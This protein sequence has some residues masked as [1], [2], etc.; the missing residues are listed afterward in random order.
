MFWKGK[1][2]MKRQYLFMVVLALLLSLLVP[3]LAITPLAGA[4]ETPTPPLTEPGPYGV[5]Q[6]RMTFI[7][8]SRGDRELET[9]IWYPVDK[10]RGTPIVP[11]GRVLNAPPDR[12]GAPYPLIVFSHDYRSFGELADTLE[13]L[14]SQGYVVAA[15]W[16]HDTQPFRYELVD[17][18]LDILVVLDGLAAITEGDLAGMI[19]TD[20]VGLMGFS[21]GGDTVLQMLGLLRDPVHFASWCAEH[22]DLTTWDCNPPPDFGPWP[23]DEITAYRAQLGLQNTPDGQWAPFGDERVRAVFAIAPGE[24]PLTTED[25]LASVTTPTM[26]LHGTNDTVCDYEGN[27]VR[28]YTHLGT[29]DRYLITAIDVTY[30]VFETQHQ[31]QVPQHFATA[32]F[33]YYLQGDET[34]QPYLTPEHLLDW[35]YPKLVWGP[36]ES[37]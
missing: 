19:D 9:D 17:R 33:G 36:Y 26:I 22:P 18:P 24:F 5:G 14:A 37:E 25:L 7:D 12:S 29:E 28:T 3:A 2:I 20:N 30:W 10:A 13:H 16:H 8:E 4:Q 1:K 31:Q 6:V 11:G 21:M 34:Y 23:L 15:P 32:F 35:S 27:A